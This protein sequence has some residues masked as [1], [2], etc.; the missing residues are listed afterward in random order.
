MGVGGWGEGE[1]FGSVDLVFGAALRAFWWVGSDCGAV[2]ATFF[3][4]LLFMGKV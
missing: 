1:V 4:S 2:F 3:G